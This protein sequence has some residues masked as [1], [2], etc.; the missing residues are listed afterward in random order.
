MSL[1]NAAGK[2]KS[3]P[4]RSPQSVP[5]DV[6][7]SPTGATL[8]DGDY[9]DIVVS[10]SGATME[11]D[12]AV[13]TAWARNLLAAADAA[14]ARAVLAAQAAHA[15][16][17]GLSGMGATVGLVEQTGVAAF[18]KRAIGA[19]SATDILSR[20]AG[21]GRYVLTTTY[22]A[23]DVLAKLLTVDGAGSLLDADLVDGEEGAFY[24]SRANH[25]GTQSIAT[26][27]GLQAA[28]D[29]KAP[30]AGP[31][32]TGIP[33]APTAAAGDNSTQLATT[34]FVSTAISNL[35]AMAP[36]ALDTLDELA[37]AL[38]DDPNFAGTVTTALAGKLAKASNLSD[39]ANVATAR[40]NLGL[41]IGTDVQ[42]FDA[43]LAAIAG[44]A[45]AADQIIYWTGLTTAATTS[46]TASA[47]SLAALNIVQGDLLYGSAAGTFSKLA[48][49]ANAS[50]YLCN[51][52]SGNDP[53]WSQVNLA[54]GVTGRLPLANFVQASATDKLLGRSS[55]GSGDWQEVDCTAFARSLLDDATAAAAR[56]TL[57]LLS[58]ATQSS[59][60]VNITGGTVFGSSVGVNSSG[61]LGGVRLE[62]GTDGGYVGFYDEAAARH[63]YVGF[64]VA[65]AAGPAGTGPRLG[66]VAEA[67]M[68]GFSV[69]GDL[70][71]SSGI[72]ALHFRVGNTQVVGGRVTGWAAMTGTATRTT[73]DTA[74]VTLAQLAQRVKALTD[75]LITHGLIGA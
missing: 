65:S 57:G 21:D 60:A 30:L 34:A 63:G 73:F 59:G 58:M 29:L 2:E 35:V 40:S 72:N 47:R 43:Q 14:A 22:V 19:A 75:D 46:F 74:T 37:A 51:G 5:Y 10:G 15:I 23:A 68:L 11:F 24:L 7:G 62:Q 1:N 49:D 17:D 54:N 27:S 55:A 50:R 28:L 67:P 16:L 48:K 6:N 8:A 52:G 4:S 20:A 39:L 38:G 18:A 64:P 44:L 36:G 71:V 9:G 69:T 56:I 25:T 33:T 61:A 41:V 12:P 26:V 53:I 13:V 70:L 45:P 66:M 42:A 3:G 31:A 32:L